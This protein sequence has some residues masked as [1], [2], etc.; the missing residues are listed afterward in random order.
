MVLAYLK[1]NPLLSWVVAGGVAVTGAAGTYVYNQ[2]PSEK[3]VE[4]VS[5]T[6]QTVAPKVEQ[7]KAEAP[8]VVEA[9]P[10]APVVAEV[11]EP[12]F[13]VLRVEKDGST[14]IAGTAPAASQ[15]EIISNGAVIAST[16]ASAAGDFAIVLDNPL[17]P[18]AHELTIRSTSV[19]G[20]VLMSSETGIVNVP[21][22]GGELLA[23]V[24]KEGEASRVLQK[25]EPAAEPVAETAAKE[26]ATEET[27]K[28]E[29]AKEETAKEEPVVQPSAEAPKQEAAQEVAK[30]EP[31]VEAK[32]ETPA[33][34]KAEEKPL[35]HK[36]QPNRLP[37]S[38]LFWCRLS[39]S[40]RPDF[41]CR[42][43]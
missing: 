9:K 7:P 13:D 18:G 39:M 29:T 28:E 35:N 33:V 25:P 30:A 37:K 16:T 14:V 17:A 6:P 31:A 23:M 10:E 43:R 1:A 15:V 41:R 12:R 32:P 21:E 42:L 22:A 40:I 5:A 4:L 20:S 3:P 19:D 2:K 26:P 34:S 27:A 24:S 11:A 36:S 38:G 8:A